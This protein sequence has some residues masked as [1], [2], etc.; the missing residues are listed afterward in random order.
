MAGSLG[1]LGGLLKQAQKM[2][3]QVQELQQDLA[4]RTYEGT[5]GGVV[6]VQVNGA[7]PPEVLGL[8]IEPE[9]CDPSDV[10]MLEEAVL[11]ALKDAFSKAQ[12]DAEEAM[13]GV[14][15]GMGMPGMPGMPGMGLPGM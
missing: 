9:A 1:D 12:Q 7:T 14:T 5:A 4:G 10:E 6:K 8:S 13:K 15:G 3:R 11:G 2:Q